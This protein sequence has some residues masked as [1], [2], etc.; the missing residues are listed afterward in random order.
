MA[1][2][3]TTRDGRAWMPRY[4]ESIDYDAC[5]GCGRCYKVCGQGVLAPIEKPVDEDF[6]D[7]EECATTVMSIG[8]AGACIGC[9]ACAKVCAKKAQTHLAVA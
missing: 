3:L 7:D 1:A 9:E 5:I 4:L 8:D 2:T 6:D